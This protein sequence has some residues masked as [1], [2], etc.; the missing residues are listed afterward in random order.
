M[1]EKSYL[2]PKREGQLLDYETFDEHTS[3]EHKWEFYEGLPFSTEPF[4][5]D[6]LTICLLYNMGLKYFVNELLPDESKEILLQ[7]LQKTIKQENEG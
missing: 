7:L 5:R 3:E 1:L 2:V 6:R 4:E